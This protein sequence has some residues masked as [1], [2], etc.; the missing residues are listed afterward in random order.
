VG[1]GRQAK[2]S[3]TASNRI[4]VRGSM[5]VARGINTMRNEKPQSFIQEFEEIDLKSI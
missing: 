2:A 4:L 3:S 1:A 5:V